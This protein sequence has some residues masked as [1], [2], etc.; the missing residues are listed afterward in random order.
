MNTRRITVVIWALSAL[1]F[2]GAGRL[3]AAEEEV[4]RESATV[5]VKGAESLTFLR[6]FDTAFRNDLAQKKVPEG[7]IE[8]VGCDSLNVRDGKPVPQKLSYFF[9]TK[10]RDP[11]SSALLAA[12]LGATPRTGAK[13]KLSFRDGVP[14]CTQYPDPTHCYVRSDCP[15]NN[16]PY[17][18]RN[19]RPP[20]GA[21]CL[22][23][24]L[25]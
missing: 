3:S 2:F 21:A 14:L 17:C 8:C 13:A 7:D 10:S 18:S 16:T 23:G 9:L 12:F 4:S 11:V 5:T 22:P 15:G 19:K 24:C 20:A 6:A 1:V 25:P